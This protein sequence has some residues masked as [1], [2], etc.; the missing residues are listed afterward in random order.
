MA[1]RRLF[2]VTPQIRSLV[3]PTLALI[4]GIGSNL[5]STQ[6]IKAYV[7]VRPIPPDF[8]FSH[9]PYIGWTQYLTDAANVFSVILL[10]YYTLPRRVHLLPGI[11]WSFAVA[12][13]MRALLILA[14][15]LGS[16]LGP[17]MQYGITN[18]L[19]IEQYGE[20]PS[21]H[22]MLVV[23]CY[24]LV[25]KND[26]PTIKTFL[27]ISIFVEIISLILSRGH[28]TIDIAGGFF[29]AY[30]AHNEVKKY[31]HRSNTIT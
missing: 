27:G 19:P 2:S 26:A 25:H 11:L 22:T 3:A 16:P 28:Y 9:T 13:I 5:L 24:L 18:F 1:P 30:V 4:L 23:L 8:F 10:A 6:L 17:N 12:E 31:L 21:G 15:P 7:P 20:F 14:T 29:I